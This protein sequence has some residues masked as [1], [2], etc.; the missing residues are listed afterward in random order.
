MNKCQNSFIFYILILYFYIFIPHKP[1]NFQQRLNKR[2]DSVIGR[3]GN[4]IYTISS[5]NI[6]N[7]FRATSVPELVQI[8][9]YGHVPKVNFPN[10]RKRFAFSNNVDEI[11]ELFQIRECEEVSGLNKDDILLTNIIDSRL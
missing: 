8:F 10:E 4:A 3:Y 2:R 5:E 9:H 7:N 11:N 1:E 6:R